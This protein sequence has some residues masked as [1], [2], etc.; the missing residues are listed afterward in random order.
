[1][2][3]ARW[4]PRRQFLQAFPQTRD[5][6]CITPFL[7]L[8]QGLFEAISLPND[9]AM[10][11]N[12]GLFSHNSASPSRAPCLRPHPGPQMRTLLYQQY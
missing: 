11:G 5:G 7:S 1:M 4:R 3:R 10:A 12:V 2:L 9:R 6:V 8:C